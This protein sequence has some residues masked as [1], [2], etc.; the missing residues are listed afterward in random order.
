MLKA[1]FRRRAK[2]ILGP[3]LAALGRLR[4]RRH[5]AR[6][7]PPVSREHPLR[8][9]AALAQHAAGGRPKGASA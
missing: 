9:L 8:E 3:P 6:D 2:A 1:T 4:R 5:L 7:L